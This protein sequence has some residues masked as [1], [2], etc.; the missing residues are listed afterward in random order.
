MLL[1]RERERRT[2]DRLLSDARSGMS[3]V[4]AVVGEPGIGKSALLAEARDA[5]RG[6]AVLHARGVESEAQV[7]FGGLLE[8]LRP[9]LGRLGSI[10]APQADALGRALALRPGPTGERFAVGAATLSLRAAEAVGRPCLFLL[11]VPRWP[12]A[13]RVAARP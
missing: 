4:L 13:S 3:A 10:P 7:P 12:A 2:L 9:A 5:A 1:G 11:Y 8:L 6:F